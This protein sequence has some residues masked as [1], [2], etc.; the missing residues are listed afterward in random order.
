MHR[1]VVAR[2]ENFKNVR[3][4]TITPNADRSIMVI[5]GRNRQGK[6]SLID[7]FT[8]AYGGKRAAPIDPVRHG[9]DRASVRIEHDSGLVIDLE[10]DKDGGSRL[11]VSDGNG[12]IKSPQSMLDDLVGHGRFLDPISFLNLSPLEQRRTLMRVIGGGQLEKLE[13]TR[14]Q[15]FD[16]R[17]EVNRDLDKAKGAVAALPAVR[18][19]AEMIDVAALAAE[20]A[21]LSDQQRG[22]DALGAVVKAVATD[23]DRATHDAER[24]RT[25]IRDLE[26]RLVTMRASLTDGEAKRSSLQQEHIEKKVKLDELAQAW[27]ESMPRRET[28]DKQLASANDH[29]SRI[30]ADIELTKRHEAAAKLVETLGAASTEATAKLDKLERR[31]HAVITEAK[32]PVEN[33]GVAQDH[34]TLNGVP[35]AQASGAEKLRTALALAI[36]ASPNLADVW[37]R[38]GSLLDEESMATVEEHARSSGHCVWI[39]RVTT[40]EA[41]AIIIEEGM[42]KS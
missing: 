25:D 29:N 36:A 42:V 16:K 8:A 26:A 5:G 20:R 24:M 17:T 22:A 21:S 9:A 2:V 27:R 4:I 31:K 13:A 11:K 28:I 7:A 3:E 32:L 6:S 33:L 15:V 37:I 12:P 1:I 39:E 14:Q 10:I 19:I 38:D 34:L 35:F 18:P 30:A 23:L 41:G 40:T